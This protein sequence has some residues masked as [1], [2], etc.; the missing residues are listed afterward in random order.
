MI[1][2]AMLGSIER[3]MGILLE[4][5]GGALPTW[6]APD[7][8]LVIPVSDRHQPYA[9]KVRDALFACGLRVALDDR[10]ESV[11]RR[12]RDGQL[13]KVPYLLVV[14]ERE[15]Q[16]AAVSVRY[17]GQEKGAMPLDEVAA[18]ILAEVRERELPPAVEPSAAD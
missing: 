1:H 14:G 9:A 2:R 11:G 4:H 10:G 3:F 17:R 7:Q 5:Y 18:L 6:L 15:V 8:A 16:A 13:Q 12:I